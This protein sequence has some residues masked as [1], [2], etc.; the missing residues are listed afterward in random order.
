MSDLY[1]A[2]ALY[3]YERHVFTL[4]VVQIHP[5]ACALRGIHAWDHRFDPKRFAARLLAEA[6]DDN[7]IRRAFPKHWE[8]TSFPF[9]KRAEPSDFEQTS[10]I[11]LIDRGGE[12]IAKFVAET[13]RDE[14]DPAQ[15]EQMYGV[16]GEYV[17]RG[18]PSH[19]AN[20]SDAMN[21][22]VTVTDPKYLA[23]IREGLEWRSAA[24]C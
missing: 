16:P 15:Y 17:N 20:F 10:L 5:D 2:T 11:D 21:L 18:E 13:G 14:V 7:E 22:T 12:A 19:Y 24:F 23:H 4:R 9:V 3:S 1:R 8:T 6:T